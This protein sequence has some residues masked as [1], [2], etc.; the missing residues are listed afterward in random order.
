MG[1]REGGRQVVREEGRDE[2][3]REVDRGSVEREERKDVGKKVD[4]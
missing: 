4:R 1:G 3:W 2:V